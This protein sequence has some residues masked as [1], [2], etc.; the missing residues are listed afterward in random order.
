VKK[1][2]PSPNNRY[3]YQMPPIQP[4]L[5]LL[6]KMPFTLV[7]VIINV[8]VF[9]VTVTLAGA[10][11]GQ[12]WTITLLRLG[13]Q[14]NP[15]SL[16]HQEYRVFTHLFLHGSVIHLAVNTYML[17]FVGVTL[18]TKVGTKK[19][20]FVYLVT[21]LAAALSGL[22]W[23]LFTIGIGMSGAIIGMLGFSLVYRIFLPGKSGKPMVILLAH[24]ALFALANVAFPQWTFPDYPAQFGGVMA[25]IF[26]GFC[27]FATGRR[28]VEKVKI[29]YVMLGVLVALYFLLPRSQVRYYRF[30]K[31]LVAAEETTKH[32]LKDKL[33]DDDMRLFI[34]NY[35]QWEDMLTRLNE[36]SNL[37]SGLATDTFK[38]RKYINIRK[39][40]N[41][42]RK[43]VVQRETYTYL[44]SLEYLEQI[45]KQYMDLD[46]KLWTSV[47]MRADNQGTSHEEPVKAYYDSGGREVAA[48]LAVWYRVGHQTGRGQWDGVV[49]DYYADGSIRMK[50]VYKGGIR[51][52]V[53]LNYSHKK[54]YTEAGRYLD[55]ERFGKWQTFH[56][57]GALASEIFYNHGTFLH[58]LWDSLG[59][60]L[61]VDGNGR[62]IQRYP[63]GVVAL[64]GEYHYGKK[65]GRWFGRYPNGQMHFEE[66]F[67]AGRLVT[68]QSRSPEGRTFIY[69]DTSLT[70]IPEGGFEKYR[71]YLKARRKE[72]PA[73]ELG[74]VKISF[75]VTA[76]GGLTDVLITQGA[77]AR[78]DAKARDIVLTGPRW[79]PAREHGYKPVEAEASLLI[80]FY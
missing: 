46:Y 60:A 18:E 69:D 33:T 68:G 51:D 25:G 24:F 15:L 36:Q 48:P 39:Q 78:L 45:M 77:T 73:E 79:L 70:P 19:F 64:E 47:K 75:R 49:R 66:T 37:P 12:Q 13:A 22:Y 35:H 4:S 67:S 56:G 58:S 41:L 44:D 14:F 30:F 71:E 9:A 10:M 38:L 65:E 3:F 8:V 20:A 2:P 63:N 28:G 59:N 72:V 34:T 55:G 57:N 7:V 29:E 53:F 23:N 80:E 54:K 52:G 17:M 27:S 40:E 42:F 26:I 5:T 62:A 6:R 32:L 76:A 1:Q 11:E 16:D 21:A 43:L 31:Q 61:V 74:H 50:G